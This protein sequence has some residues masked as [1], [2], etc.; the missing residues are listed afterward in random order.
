MSLPNRRA[1]QG[2]ERLEQRTSTRGGQGCRTLTVLVDEHAEGDAVGVE[3]VQE[4]LHVA[5]DEGV[6]AELLLVLDDP[7]GHGGN[8]VIVSVTDLDQELQKA[9]KNLGKKD[10]SLV[11]FQFKLCLC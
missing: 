4:V 6:E 10:L 1:A 9:A 7:L 5:A 8:H 11:S 3:A 2:K